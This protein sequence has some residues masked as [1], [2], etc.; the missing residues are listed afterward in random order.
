MSLQGTVDACLA[1][2]AMLERGRRV[3]AAV[4]GGADSVFLLDALHRR[5]L[6]AA[7]I[8]VN[9]K[10]R[11][12]E[13]DA[14]ESFVAE[15]A[16]RLNLPFRAHGAPA[17]PGNLEQEARRARY[18]FFDQA[19]TEGA[20]DVVATGHTLDDQAETVLGRFLRGA[21]TAGLSGI[22]P[23][24]RDRIIRPL[25]GL[26][27]EDI[28]ADL[29][30]RGMVWRDDCT[31]SRT[32]FLRNRLRIEIM[33]QLTQLNPSLPDVLGTMAEW[34][35][36]EEEWWTGEIDRLEPT[37]FETAEQTVLFRT[38]NLLAH[39]EATQRRLLRRAIERV[40]GS[41]RAI[42]FRHVEAIRELARGR[43]GS[44]R[45]Q[46]PG[47]DVFRSFD[48]LRLAPPGIDGRQDRNFEQ[49][50][51]APGVTMVPDRLL[52][53]EMEPVTQAAVYNNEMNVLDWDRCE[54]SLTVRNWRPGDS[55]RPAGKTGAEKI[56][57]LFQEYRVPLWERRRWPVIVRGESIVWTRRF[58]VA[59]EFA[60]GP[61][62]RRM[63]SIREIP[64][65]VPGGESNPTLGT[66]IGVG[67]RTRRP[68]EPG[69][70]VL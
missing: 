26:R 43:E 3:G 34:A 27:R 22:R 9:H 58:G 6:A 13:S 5:G 59:G 32:E 28:R 61:S 48:W 19:I 12:A 65:Q 51:V 4:S 50:V 54:G 67:A 18:R 52:T 44:G 29:R 23:V 21:G 11:G 24:T 42:D 46:I 57:T 41:L 31:N 10:L 53:I 38:V 68:G 25:L 2:Y 33:P 49:P 14:D 36:G 7:V 30:A 70:E 16:C 60:A 69:A 17:A 20:C 8:H 64:A 47:V 15:L 56:K 45:I 1:R 62:S 39:P 35:R 37:I 66:S 63:L 40:Q 55:Y